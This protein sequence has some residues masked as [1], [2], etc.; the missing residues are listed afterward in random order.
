MTLLWAGSTALLRRIPGLV[1]V[2]VAVVGGV[3]V[4]FVDVID[5]VA[6][7]DR[8]VPA[9][10]AVSVGVGVGQVRQRV[11]VVVA[12]VAGVGVPF[13]DVVGVACTLHAGVPALRAV[14]V[15]V[16]G[17]DFVL[18]GGHCSSLL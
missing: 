11:L 9:V 10:G 4:P 1:L 15:G 7:R 13:V 18:G 6:V 17:M 5:M 12:I 2:V 16:R 3:T 8:L 14:L